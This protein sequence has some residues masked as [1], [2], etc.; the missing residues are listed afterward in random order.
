MKNLQYS[1]LVF[2][3]ACSYGVLSTILKLG[4]AEGFTVSQILGGQYLFGWLILLVAML[5]FS[6][7]KVKLKQVGTLLLAGI[8]MSL[9]GVFYGVSVEQLPASLAVLLLFQFTWMGV[10]LEAIWERKMPS[11]GKLISIAVLIVGT[12]LAGGVLEQNSGQ[13][14]LMGVLC[15]LLAALTFAIYIFA[16]GKVATNV[17]VFSRSFIMLTGALILLLIIL[18][19]TFLFDGSIV[20]GAWKF[21]LPQALMGS[22]IPVVFFAIGIPKI[23]PGL[24]AILG[25]AELPAAVIVSI[26][27]LGEMVSVLQ[28]VGIVLI[29]LGI[30][31][32]QLIPQ[33]DRESAKRTKLASQMEQS[34]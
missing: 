34:A 4:L 7:V 30:V 32:P 31:V 2:L 19:P 10:V 21:S 22:F 14:T 9:T 20:Q 26:V 13:W 5:L 27:V 18:T 28:W 25:A 6:R 15:G 17:P 23:G 12:L 11:R 24:G 16:S 33:G 29:L 3:G 8:P 1:V